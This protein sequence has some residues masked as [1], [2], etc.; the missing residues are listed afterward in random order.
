[1][2]MHKTTLLMLA[3]TAAALSLSSG[4]ALAAPTCENGPIQIGA[5]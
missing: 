5:V 3:G 4:A 1:M 2:T